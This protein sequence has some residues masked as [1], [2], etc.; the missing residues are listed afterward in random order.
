MR[1]LT[2]VTILCLLSTRP[3]PVC[4]T[5]NASPGP[6]ARMVSAAGTCFRVTAMTM[7]Q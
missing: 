4:S 1:S 2:L 5:Q 3:S 7:S 6:R